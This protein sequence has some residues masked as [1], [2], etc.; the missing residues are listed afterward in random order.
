MVLVLALLALPA[1]V[2]VQVGNH[3]MYVLL[4]WFVGVVGTD[5]G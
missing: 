5:F 1:Q 3:V 4:T 2:L